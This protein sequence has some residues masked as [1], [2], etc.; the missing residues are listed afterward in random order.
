[1]RKKY[2]NLLEI[3]VMKQQTYT[4]NDREYSREQL[5]AF[6]KEHYPKL[7]WIPR[8]AGII[9][10]IVGLFVCGM[11][12]LVMLILKLTGVFDTPDF[13]I[14]VFYIPLGLFGGIGVGGI[15]CIVVSCLG[16]SDQTYIDHALA[17][18]T[19]AEINNNVPPEMKRT[20]TLLRQEDIERL[21]RNERLLKGGVITQEE[22][23]RRRKE[24]LGE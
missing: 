15:I 4:V 23:D 22:Y 16:R 6:G 1:M 20:D 2:N 21:E 24:I 19:K 8:I 17:Y 3:N 18:L 11:L 12:G 5:I 13:P 14:W 7:Y 9:L 10:L